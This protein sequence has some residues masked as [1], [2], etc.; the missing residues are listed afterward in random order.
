MRIGP[1]SEWQCRRQRSQGGEFGGRRKRN[2]EGGRRE[3][4]G[5]ALEMKRER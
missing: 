4:E 2:V 5:K 3:R 1:G